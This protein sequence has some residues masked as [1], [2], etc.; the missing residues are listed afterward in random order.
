L[1]IALLALAGALLGTVLRALIFWYAVEPDLPWR[2]ACPH[3][4]AV[5]ARGGWP[6]AGRPLHPSGRCPS[7]RARI[8]PLPG[9][10][11]AVTAAAFGLLAGRIAEPWPLAAACWVAAVCV[12]LGFVDVA[13]H[14]L[15]DRL[16]MAACGGALVL[17]AVAAAVE[18]DAAGLG[19]AVVGGLGLAAF[20]FL[21]WFINPSG[22]GFGDVKLALSLGTVL[23]WYG[24][25]AVVYGAAV[26]AL[27]GGVV[28]ASLWAS[29][30]VGRK[31]PVPYGPSMMIGALAILVL[32]A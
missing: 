9:L 11:E 29:A 5:L 18:G 16:T 14:R 31:D 24:W 17:L 23:G 4:D 12:V 27:V 21:L 2:S 32:A 25:V 28:V 26:G 6:G 10:V 8:G 13:V 22:F 30:R 20:Y 15:P 7:C 1:T 19:W 3:C